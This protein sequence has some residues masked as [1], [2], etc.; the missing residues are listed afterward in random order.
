MVDYRLPA[1]AGFQGARPLLL[2]SEAAGCRYNAR[3]LLRRRLSALCA[4]FGPL[5][6]GKERSLLALVVLLRP[7]VID[8]D[9]MAPKP[10]R[11]I[12]AVSPFFLGEQFL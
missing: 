4:R 1:A 5:Y 7:G 6:K 10:A 2:P 3:P 12:N 8:S 9:P 11:Q